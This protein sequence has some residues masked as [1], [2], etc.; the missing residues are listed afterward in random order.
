MLKLNHN[1]F[2]HRWKKKS[3][4]GSLKMYVCSKGRGLDPQK[5]VCTYKPSCRDREK[6]LIRVDLK[7]SKL[8]RFTWHCGGTS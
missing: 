6:N 2:R 5:H 4:L 7:I 3:V 8:S 1:I